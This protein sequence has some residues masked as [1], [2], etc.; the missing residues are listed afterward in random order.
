MVDFFGKWLVAGWQNMVFYAFYITLYA[1]IAIGIT[2]M[3]LWLKAQGL[4]EGTIGMCMAAAA[5]VAVVINPLAGTFAD[6]VP[7]SGVAGADRHR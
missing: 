6:A 2:F 7:R 5:T 4:S 3:P 1:Q